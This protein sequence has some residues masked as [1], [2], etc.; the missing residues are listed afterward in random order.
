MNHVILCFNFVSKNL[1]FIDWCMLL[2]YDWNKANIKTQNVQSKK[3][4]NT[5]SCQLLLLARYKVQQSTTKYCEQKW[6]FF[7]GSRC[8]AT[9]STNQMTR[10]HSEN[11]T[12]WIKP[13]I[14][15][16]QQILR[17]LYHIFWKK[18]KITIWSML[19]SKK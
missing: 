4:N 12:R 6:G 14:E 1:L 8:W 3:V 18:N 16:Y 13:N 19:S 11:L 10:I 5:W 17:N 9:G 7:L 2:Y 15:D